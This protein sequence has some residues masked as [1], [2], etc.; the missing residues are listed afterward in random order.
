MITKIIHETKP[1]TLLSRIKDW[2]LTN[3]CQAML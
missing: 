3:F 2:Y 1:S